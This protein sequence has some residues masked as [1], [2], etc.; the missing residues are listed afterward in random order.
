MGQNGEFGADRA[1]GRA[2]HLFC[3]TLGR[4]S[5]LRVEDLVEILDRA[6]E[7]RPAVRHV[8]AVVVE[9][10]RAVPS[11][12]SLERA[13]AASCQ[14]ESSLARALQRAK[15]RGELPPG[16][17]PVELARFL[18]TFVQG[19]RVVGSARLG[20]SFVEDALAVAM[21]ALDRP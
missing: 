12:G 19:L 10:D 15:A 9:A 8:L 13:A 16:K 6:T 3:R 7:I 4:S 11:R 14:V 5:A 21:R 18:A 17:D 2:A 1:V 20:R